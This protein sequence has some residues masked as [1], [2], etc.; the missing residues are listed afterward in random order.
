MPN[1]ISFY[2]GIF[3]HVIPVRIIVPWSNQKYPGKDNIPVELINH[4]PNIAHQQIPV[5]MNNTFLEHEPNDFGTGILF[6]LPKLN[7]SK[8]AVKRL[9]PIILLEISRKILPKILLNRIQPKVDTYQSKSQSAYKI[10]RSTTCCMDIQ[11][12]SIKNTRTR[13]NNI[14]NR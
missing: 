14:L 1:S 12:G 13:F 4:A 8:G 3:L 5:I 11:M 9:S 2:K 6:P 7:R 10:G